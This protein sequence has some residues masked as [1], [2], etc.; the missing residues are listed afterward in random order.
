MLIQIQL[1]KF[2]SWLSLE[3]KLY[4][5]K[6]FERLKANEAYQ[7]GLRAYNEYFATVSLS[8]VDSRYTWAQ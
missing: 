4:L 7:V 3:F 6:E 5:I 1:P 8:N 2:A